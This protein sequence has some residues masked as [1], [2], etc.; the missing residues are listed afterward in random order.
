M[1]EIDK[2]IRA[3]K[4]DDYLMS[5]SADERRALPVNPAGLVEFSGADQ[6][7]AALTSSSLGHFSTR[8]EVLCLCCV[9]GR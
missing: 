3:W 1:Q 8:I 7:Q 5:L 2:I 9:V 4:D 6:I